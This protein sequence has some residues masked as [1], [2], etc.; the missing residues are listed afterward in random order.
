MRTFNHR[1]GN[2]SLA[3]LVLLV[4]ATLLSVAACDTT[5]KSP[6]EEVADTP[7]APAPSVEP[8][9]SPTPELMFVQSAEG[10]EV[11]PESST[12]R[13]V[14]VDQQTIYFTDRPYR[15]AGHLKMPEYL[16][17]WTAKAG[18]DNF[19]ADPPNAALSVYQAGQPD[20]TVAVVE[21]TQPVVDGADLVYTYEVIEGPMP[22]GGGQM[23]LFIDWIGP[24]GGVGPGYHGVGIGRR[25]PG[26]I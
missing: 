18:E 6:S 16:E 22:K 8:G 19:G 21:I 7:E 15:I 13:L 4:A 23:A 2:R 26:V 17:E 10:L 1:D 25:G 5:S 24:G 12:M 20:S 9:S 3:C 11:D 14:N